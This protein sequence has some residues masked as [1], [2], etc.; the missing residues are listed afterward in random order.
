MAVQPFAVTAC[1]P[2]Q[3]NPARATRHAALLAHHL[4]AST[5]Q[6]FDYLQQCVDD[7]AHLAAGS[8]HALDS[9][10]NSRANSTRS[11]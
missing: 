10:Q 2:V 11:R 1:C 6:T 3:A 7:P 9:R 5:L 4:N 8:L